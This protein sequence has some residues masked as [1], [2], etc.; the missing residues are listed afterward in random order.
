[1]AKQAQQQNKKK[2]KISTVLIFLFC[3]IVAFTMLVPFVWM[4]SASFK[5]NSEI[6]S[7][8]HHPAP[9]VHLLPCGLCI[10]QAAVSGKR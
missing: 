7:G 2:L 10:Y 1:M 4:V 5:L 9:A 3:C 8:Y 6:F